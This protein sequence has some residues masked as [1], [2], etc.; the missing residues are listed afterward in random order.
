MTAL[1][2]FTMH[3]IEAAAWDVSRTAR[4]C[5]AD[6]DETGNFPETEFQALHAHG[7]LTAP[8]PR[9]LGGLG[10]GSECGEMHALMRILAIL[11]WGNLSLARLYEGHANALLLVA[12]FG[13]EKQQE[14]AATD[15]ENVRMTIAVLLGSELDIISMPA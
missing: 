1:Q 4:E 9:S 12:T 13:T 11:G 8:L 7:L 10:L 14:Q 2:R 5:A 15:A 6:R 3:R